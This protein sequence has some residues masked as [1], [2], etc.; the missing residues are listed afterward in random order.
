MNILK[1]F[2]FIS[3]PTNSFIT[4]YYYSRSTIHSNHHRIRNIHPL[5][6]T[7]STS[8]DFIEEYSNW[9]GMFPP[10][11]KWKSVRFTLYTIFSGY[12]LAEFFQQANEFINTP[13]IRF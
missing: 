9:F 8:H 6:S 3:V 13:N 12:L 2:I 5:M 1:Y 4:K 10:E 7:N 11:K